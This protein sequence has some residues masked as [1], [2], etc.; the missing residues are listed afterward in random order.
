MPPG[1]DV[2]TASVQV[3]EM[4]RRIYAESED[5]RVS[6]MEALAV[7]LWRSAGG[8]RSGS[9]FAVMGAA[10]FLVL[11]IAC[12]NASGI[13]FS[14]ATS[15][16]RELSIRAALGAGRT[17]L[18]SL[19]L[20]ETTLLAL[21]GGALGLGAA[22]IG[23]RQ[24]LRLA[25]PSVPTI[26]DVR[27]NATVLA[28]ALGISVLAS[29][30][31]GLV[32][33]LHASRR[34]VTGGLNEGS[35]Q[36]TSG[37]GGRRLRR[38]L[39]V[40]ELAL[41]LTLLV[42]AGLTI[43]GFQRQLS[44]D[45]GF[46]ASNLLTFTVRLPASRYGDPAQVDQYF[47]EAR[48]RIEA[49]PGA[50]SA[51]T[52]SLLPLGAGGF[53]LYRAFLV[54]GEPEPPQGALHDASW[55][56]VDPEYFR[57]LG[58]RPQ[59]GRAFSTDDQLGAPP[60]I[61]V[62]TVLAHRMSPEGPLV[63]RQI[64]S[65]YDENLP[66]TVVGVVPDIQLDGMAGREEPMVFVPRSQS[67]RRAM[68]FMIRTAGDPHS[69]V[70][71][72]RRTMAELDADVALDGL[73]TLRE[74]H[75]TDLAGVRFLS[76]LFGAF[77]LLALILSMSGVYGLVSHSVTRRTQEIGVWMAMGAPPGRVRA[78]VVSEAAVLA[79]LG[80][81]IGLAL[82]YASSRVLS[83]VLFGLP[84]L[85]PTTFASLA[86]FLAFATL[87]AAWLPARRATRVDPVEALRLG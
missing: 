22:V 82:A 84:G 60:V 53:S 52:T 83:A 77:G 79:L 80:V 27:L 29:V 19:L 31:S 35:H 86:A 38:G 43:R 2:R 13:L 50:V 42:A 66:R 72:V 58:L 26:L 28:A 5:E 56:E 36:A 81:G 45:P 73:G 10:V 61:M 41:S 85:D 70:G 33:A 75:R 65:Y 87:G 40:A 57:T 64:R 20:A 24:A 63:G 12:M 4:A 76:T 7:P 9:I 39:V 44:T 55:V 37:R 21:L 17:R 48:S 68:A 25:P 49:L 78:R 46:D 51:S 1:V 32:P 47:Q 62:N 69:L 14:H 8:E 11:L 16:G 34:S 15:R 54:E 6:G 71:D 3:R 30:A 23:V 18:V 74:A 67:P 59:K